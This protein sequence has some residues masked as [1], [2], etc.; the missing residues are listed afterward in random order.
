M[1]ASASHRPTIAP[2]ADSAASRDERWAAVLARSAAHDGRFVYAVT[3][4]GI[5][6]RPSCPS[7]RPRA[8]HVCFFPAPREAESGG[9]RACLRCRPASDAA[10]ADA[11][12][13][14]VKRLI[15]RHVDAGDE[16]PLTLGTLARE[17]ALSPHHL[18]R[19]FKQ[20][21]GLSP[22]RYAAA[23]RADRLKTRLRQGDTVTRATYE[24][25]FASPSRA[26]AVAESAL[27]MTPAAYR[28]GGRGTH[29]RY[30]VV[31]SSLGRVLVAATERGVCAVSLGDDD[32]ALEAGLATELPEAELARDDDGL[33]AWAGDVVRSVEGALSPASVPLDVAGTVF[34]RR[35]WDALRAI[36][37][38]ETRSYADL[39]AELGTP[40]GARAVA[41]ACATNP[42]AVLTP[43][44]RVVRGDGSLGGY[45]WGLDRKQQLLDRERR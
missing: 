6:C 4:T 23:R 25:G 22:S 5:Y 36:P 34:Q 12:I 19:T 41:R 30:T 26:Y 10:P 44:H 13:E 29:V 40:T 31:P 33:A 21:V 37:A 27:G 3:T 20:R 24:A 35:V 42:V 15:D 1:P 8:E 2:P 43:C 7:R 18:Q 39:A 11:A 9:F 16:R 17:A 32:S 38:G 28:R 14:R 45:R